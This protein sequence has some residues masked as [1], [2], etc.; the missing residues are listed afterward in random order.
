MTLW[1]PSLPRPNI[2]LYAIISGD[3]DFTELI[4]KLADY[5]KYTIGI[6]LRAATS[7]LL[8]RACDEFIFYETLVVE[9]VTDLADE[10]QLPTHATCCAGR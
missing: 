1:K 8:R 5:G 6:G 9:E 3:S 2:D 10:L 7:D 4:H